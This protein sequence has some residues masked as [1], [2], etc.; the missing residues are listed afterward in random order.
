MKRID[1][2]KELHTQTVYEIKDELLNRSQG[3][4]ATYNEIVK[5]YRDFINSKMG[6]DEYNSTRCTDQEFSDYKAIEL[7]PF[8][9]EDFEPPYRLVF[10]FITIKPNSIK[11]SQLQVSFIRDKER[12]HRRD[13]EKEVER[14]AAYVYDAFKF[15]EACKMAIAELL[16]QKPAEET[17]KKPT[18]QTK[19]LLLDGSQ[20]NLSERYKIANEVLDIETKI[21]TLKIADLEKYQLLAYI[22]GCDKDNARN[23]MNGTYNS[24]D[25]DLITYFNDLGLNK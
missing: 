18:K 20:L 6:V 4:T 25:R 17:E 23:I 1:F 12:V 9:A 7:T 13:Y 11:V 5:D 8:T 10:D 16:E 24:K 19:S 22:L 3:T 2:F 14:I 21:R 15:R